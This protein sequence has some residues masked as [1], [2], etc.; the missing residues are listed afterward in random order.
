MLLFLIHLEFLK[1][2]NEASMSPKEA[3]AMVIG[4]SNMMST[5]WSSMPL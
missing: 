3:S 2:K 4:R 5:F 1:G